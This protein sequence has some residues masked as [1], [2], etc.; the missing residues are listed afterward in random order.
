MDNPS[1]YMVNETNDGGVRFSA[2]DTAMPGL[3]AIFLSQGY[4]ITT[5]AEYDQALRN[6]EL[7]DAEV[8]EE[9][10]YND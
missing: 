9:S 3:I 1:I 10:R 4:R 7:V 2:P 8:A 6:A 5:R